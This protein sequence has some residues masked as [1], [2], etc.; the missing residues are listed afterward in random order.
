MISNLTIFSLCAY[1]LFPAFSRLHINYQTIRL[2]FNSLDTIYKFINSSNQEIDNEIDNKENFVFKTI[3]RNIS[4]LDNM[5][6]H[7]ILDARNKILFKNLSFE[8]TK[9]RN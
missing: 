7:N 9:V 3:D 5:F 1:R 4:K 8:I 2:R 6:S